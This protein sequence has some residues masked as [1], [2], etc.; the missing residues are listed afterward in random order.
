[1]RCGCAAMEN[2]KKKRFIPENYI[3]AISVLQFWGNVMKINWSV[4]Q[5][6]FSLNQYMFSCLFFVVGGLRFLSQMLPVALFLSKVAQ[7]QSALQPFYMA[8]LTSQRPDVEEMAVQQLAVQ[9]LPQGMSH[10]LFDLVFF[11]TEHSFL[12]GILE[13]R[14]QWANNHP[15]KVKDD[16]NLTWEMETNQIRNSNFTFALWGCD[17]AQTHLLIFSHRFIRC[18]SSTQQ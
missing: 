15:V 8:P 12:G 1:M 13:W 17:W 4:S 14:L 6:Y 3:C 2:S 10:Q 16:S 7:H 18:L 11:L 5:L 9:Y